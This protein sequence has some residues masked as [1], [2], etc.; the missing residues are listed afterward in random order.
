MEANQYFVL[1]EDSDKLDVFVGTYSVKPKYSVLFFANDFRKARFNKDPRIK[2]NEDATVVE[3]I[4]QEELYERHQA[5]IADLDAECTAKISAYFQ[6]HVEKKVA[7]DT[8]IPQEILDRRAADIAEYHQ[9]VFEATG[10]SQQ[11]KNTQK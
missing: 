7:T 4:T 1:R 10:I 2:G 11:S 5:I 8:P 9:A 6:K 3:G